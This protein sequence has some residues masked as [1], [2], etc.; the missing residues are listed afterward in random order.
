MRETYF[1]D[2]PV[3]R[4][5]EKKFHQDRDAWVDSIMYP[6]NFLQA[7]ELRVRDQVNLEYLASRRA[8]LADCYGCWMF[9]DIV[10]YI[11]LFILGTQVRGEYFAVDKKRMFKTLTKKFIWHTDKLVP[12]VDIRKP[13]SRR[14]ILEA[15]Q[16]Y[17]DGCKKHLPRRHIDTSIFDSIADHVDWPSFL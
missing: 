1:F 13:Y 10:G 4:I 2:L 17:I 6:K 15:I 14:D 3:Y 8:R 7:E 9:N 5:S 16:N 12:E 11:R